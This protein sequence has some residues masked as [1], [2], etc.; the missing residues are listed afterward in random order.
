[1]LLK[2]ENMLLKGKNIIIT[3]SNRGIGRAMVEVFAENGANIWAH[4]RKETDAFTTD[5]KKVS[6]K[7]NVE[8]WPLY[9]DL[10][11]ST[12][13]KNAVKEL[14]GYKK[15]ID[16][17]INNAGIIYNALF[18]M[19]REEDLRE[20]FEVNFFSMFLFTQYISK[21]MVRQKHGNIVN[22]ASIAAIDGVSGK[23][24]YGSTKAAVICMT[25]CIA[26]E[27]GNKGI[28]ANCIAPG[29]TETEMLETMPASEVQQSIDLSD[30]RRGG[31]PNEIAN[32]AVFL[33]SDLS[34]YITGQ[35][36]R[37]DG[38]VN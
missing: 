34:S 26:E 37:V 14:R 29:I 8:I 21:L 30:L 17:L 35:T 15:S 19:S 24:V 12:E 16:A 23:S 10:K 7:Y 28:R 6:E 27:L 9:F 3:G 4:A 5:M 25:K 36:L 20:Q 32:T 33:A 1:M 31:K 22:I 18:Q 13:M 38:G 2:G 11:N